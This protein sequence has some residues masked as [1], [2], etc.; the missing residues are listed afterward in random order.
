[1]TTPTTARTGK[2]KDKE[3]F[4]A[5]EQTILA[6]PWHRGDLPVTLGT[7]LHRRR[8]IMVDDEQMRI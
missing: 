5:N 4:V 8:I 3:L 7:A 2:Q 6:A 1:M